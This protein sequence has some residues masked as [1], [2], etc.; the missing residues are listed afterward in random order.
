MYCCMT[1]LIKAMNSY[2]NYLI[3][4][5]N[6]THR[7]CNWVSAKDSTFWKLPLY[8]QWTSIHLTHDSLNTGIANFDRRVECKDSVQSRCYQCRLTHKWINMMWHFTYMECFFL[9]LRTLNSS[10]ITMRDLFLLTL[11]FSH[12]LW[13]IYWNF[14]CYVWTCF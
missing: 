14:S 3:I 6:R 2:S 10:D 1:L 11:R 4:S 5:H 13:G 8:R 12:T 7:G 9:V